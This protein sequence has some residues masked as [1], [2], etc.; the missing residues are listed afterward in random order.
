[1]SFAVRRGIDAEAIARAREHDDVIGRFLEMIAG[2]EPRATYNLA[3]AARTVGLDEAV[4]LRLWVA[5]GLGDQ[6]EAFDEDI[7]ML[8]VLA[9]ALEAGMPIDAL[10]QLT[11]FLNDALTRVAETETRLFHFYVHERL[12]T[13]GLTGPRTRRRHR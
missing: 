4:V 7:E 10:L 6:P 2:T 3:D 8:R 1:M 11:R 9:V 12:R 5:S 13:G